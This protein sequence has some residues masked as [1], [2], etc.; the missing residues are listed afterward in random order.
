MSNI[1]ISFPMFGEDF[2]INPKEYVELFG[3][4]IYWYAIIILT[5]L[6]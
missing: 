2:A 1:V 6:I 5:G 3:F 4:K